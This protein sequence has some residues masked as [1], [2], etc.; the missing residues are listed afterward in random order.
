MSTDNRDPFALA[1]QPDD[2]AE[3]FELID[4]YRR[5]DER[6]DP[7]LSEVFETIDR[8]RPLTMRGVS[9]V[10]DL[11]AD[12]WL[13]CGWHPTEAIEALREIVAEARP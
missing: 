8:H 4:E 1:R 3:L 5:L 2:D 7:A 12:G 11:Y 6:D 13:D 9:A 10:L